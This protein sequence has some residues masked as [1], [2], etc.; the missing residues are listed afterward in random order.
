MYR[1]FVYAHRGASAYAFENTLKAFE[2]AVQIGADGIEIDVQLTK[3]GVPV[4][5]HDLNLFRLTGKRK[6]VTAMTYNK[7]KKRKVGKP[8]KRLLHG[9]KILTLKEVV[10]WAIEKQ[11]ALNV[12]LKESFLSEPLFV[13]EIIRK[14][15]GI[16]DL[17]F[18]SFHYELLK[19]IKSSHPKVQTCTL[20]IK[21]NK[22]VRITSF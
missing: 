3:D 6:L 2:N 9:E 7:L 18:S 20:T 21:R 11:I 13:K 8:F 19:V 10:E 5:I 4:V 16:K 1:V 17:H 12:E 22:L 15:R 14:C